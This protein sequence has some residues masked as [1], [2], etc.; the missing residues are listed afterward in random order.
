[1]ED[2]DEDKPSKRIVKSAIKGSRAVATVVFGGLAM[3]FGAKKVRDG[4]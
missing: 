1:M 2:D 3:A 4:N